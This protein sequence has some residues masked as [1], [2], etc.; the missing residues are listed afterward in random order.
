MKKNDLLKKD[1]LIVRILD[2]GINEVL[3]INCINKM[4]PKWVDKSSLDSFVK[5]SENELTEQN[6]VIFE[7]V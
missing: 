4:M 6:R 5:S 1:D 2:I 3:I 7:S